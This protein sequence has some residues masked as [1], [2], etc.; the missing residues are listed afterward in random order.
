MTKEKNEK[1]KNIV[2]KTA[3]IYLEKMVYNDGA[4]RVNERLGANRVNTILGLILPGSKP[5]LEKLVNMI[6]G[7]ITDKYYQNFVRDILI[8]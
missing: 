4:L 6:K 3:E 8:F 7:E 1:M 2:D 5:I